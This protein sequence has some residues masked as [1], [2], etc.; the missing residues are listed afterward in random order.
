MEL[1]SSLF[2]GPKHSC[3]LNKCHPMTTAQF[4]FCTSPPL[5]VGVYRWFR[6]SAILRSGVRFTFR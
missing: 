6:L 5:P 2:K 1:K 3:L 4:V